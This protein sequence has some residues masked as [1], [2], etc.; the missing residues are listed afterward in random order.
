VHVWNIL[1]KLR[2]ASRAGAA[3]K[4]HALCLLDLYAGW[5]TAFMVAT[6]GVTR[7]G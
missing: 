2:A 7:P 3:V 6:W 4:A 1:G 5:F